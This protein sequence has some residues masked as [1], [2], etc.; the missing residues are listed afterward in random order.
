MFCYTLLFKESSYGA[1]FNGFHKFFIAKTID[2]Q[3]ITHY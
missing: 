1:I 3:S 2:F